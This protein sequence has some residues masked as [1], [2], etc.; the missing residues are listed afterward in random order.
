MVGLSPT[1]ATSF[2][3]MTVADGEAPNGVGKYGVGR[4]V[5]HMAED[6]FGNEFTVA[7]WCNYTAGWG[8]SNHLICCKNYGDNTSNTHWYFSIYGG[9][10]LAIG[11]NA[12][13]AAIKAQYTFTKNT[14]YHLAVTYDGK[15]Y[16]LFVNGNVIKTG[17]VTNVKI[18]G[19]VNIGV[20]CRGKN[21]AGTTATG[22]ETWKFS[23]F[24][25]YDNAL[26]ED[27]I[28]K[29]YQPNNVVYHFS[30]TWNNNLETFGDVKGVDPIIFAS[31]HGLTMSGSSVWF[32]G[33]NS[34]YINFDGLKLSGGT[35]SM[36]L[37]IPAAP[38]TYAVFYCDPTSR[39]CIGC[40]KGTYLMPSASGS[41][42]VV[43][44]MNTITYGS[45]THI[46][47]VY[48]SDSV[49]TLVYINGK[50]AAENT[51]TNNWGVSGEIASI[52]R[53]IGGTAYPFSGTV[54]DIT[55]FNTQLTADEIVKIYNNRPSEE[56]SYIP[57][58]CLRFNGQQYLNIGTLSATN[59][60]RVELDF[61]PVSDS[62]N[63]PTFLSVVGKSIQFYRGSSS[64]SVSVW[65][66]NKSYT[67]GTVVENQPNKLVFTSTASN[68]K[69]SW[70]GG[71]ESNQS[72][73]AYFSLLKGGDM[74]I[75]IYGNLTNYPF[76]GDIYG[77]K[78]YCDDVLRN[79]LIP[80]VNSNGRVGFVDRKDG[81]WYFSQTSNDFE[82]IL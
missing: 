33:E 42:K 38:S 20:G 60:I 58:K 21:N 16:R 37:N 35:V 40:Y 1:S 4:S 62:L 2:S 50:Q 5:F 28:M 45:P 25:I 53:R 23:D 47:V 34:S 26:S 55:V 24:R 46:A 10:S 57:V 11:I 36:W 61:L 75:G 74:V 80:A 72:N 19:N 51:Q 67:F 13:A 8:S 31:G 63:Q 18:D 14:W 68:F 81:T 77:M 59:S 79:D 9:T 7:C 54:R 69:Y 12:G 15:T 43:Y 49:P 71:T 17:E 70:N 73:T 78:V 32:N 44:K 82:L 56:N 27:D 76:Y 66:S 3:T 64:L 41:S 22:S 52:G 6:E 29:L 39:M 48:N 30:S 65:T